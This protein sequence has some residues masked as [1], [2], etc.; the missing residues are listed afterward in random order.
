MK[1]LVGIAALVV[2]ML[3]TGLVTSIPSATTSRMVATELQPDHLPAYAHFD[4]ADWR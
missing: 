1:A 3:G 2:V 4:V